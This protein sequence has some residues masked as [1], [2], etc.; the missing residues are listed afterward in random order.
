MGR[1]MSNM[2]DHGRDQVST[3]GRSLCPS[4]WHNGECSYLGVVCCFLGIRTLSASPSKHIQ[5]PLYAF[6]LY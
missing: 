5:K 1:G 6:P 3:T 4:L 2:Q